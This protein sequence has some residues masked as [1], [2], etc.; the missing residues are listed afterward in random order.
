M[1]VRSIP[2]CAGEP[3]EQDVVGK[4]QRVY[5][6]VC[7]GTTIGRNYFNNYLGLSPRVRGNRQPGGQRFRF[8]RSIPACAG[9]PPARRRAR[10]RR[11]VYPR[12]CGGTHYDQVYVPVKE[13]LSPR[14]RG[15]RIRK[16]RRMVVRGSIPACAGEPRVSAPRRRLCGVYPRVCGGTSQPAGSARS[17]RGLSPRVRGNHPRAGRHRQ[18]E[19]SIPACAGEPAGAGARTPGRVVY[20]RVC[21]GTA[22]C[23]AAELEERGLSPRVRG[24]LG[25]ISGPLWP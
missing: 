14:V 8:A 5:P 6:R 19:R 13:G 4:T 10:R 18:R 24:N 11:G 25:R 23:E 2:A 22:A 16:H 7:G 17:V 21:G 12:V 9:E 15:N 1:A 3:G 20:P